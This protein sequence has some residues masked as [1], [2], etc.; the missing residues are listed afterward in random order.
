MTPREPDPHGQA[1]LLLMD[2]LI[3]ALIDA[4]CLSTAQAVELVHDAAT[5]HAET[6]IADAELSRRHDDSLGLLH[7]LAAGLRIDLEK[8]RLV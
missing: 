5:V 2:S 6:E 4:D 1:A 7:R 8:P 3:H